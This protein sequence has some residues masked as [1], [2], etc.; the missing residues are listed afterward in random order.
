MCGKSVV[1]I[2]DTHRA[3]TWRI[4][5]NDREYDVIFDRG[6]KLWLIDRLDEVKPEHWDAV[7]V[8][9]SEQ[10]P[11]EFLHRAGIGRLVHRRGTPW[12]HKQR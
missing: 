7:E 11:S 10:P 8:Y 9:K 1:A 3:I 12:T 2:H 5:T 4:E 6:R